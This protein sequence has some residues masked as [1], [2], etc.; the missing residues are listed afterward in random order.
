MNI[1]VG[2]G[3]DRTYT[4]TEADTAAA[5]G[6]GDVPVLGTPRVIAWCEAVT[7]DAVAAVLEA[8]QTSVGIQ[9]TIDHLK[10]TPVGVAVEV[11]ATVSEVDGR[12]I[13]FAVQAADGNGVAAAGTITRVVVDRQTFIERVSD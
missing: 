12:R 5:V 9:V 1:T 7:V 10:A 4:V 11:V 3:A 6:S 2:A 8:G 13:T